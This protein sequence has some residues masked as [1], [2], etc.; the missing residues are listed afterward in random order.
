MKGLFET[1]INVLEEA[2]SNSQITNPIEKKLQVKF[3]YEDESSWRVGEIYVFGKN[4]LGNELLRIYQTEGP[5]QRGNNQWKTFR[6]DKIK[7]LKV[8]KTF[9]FFDKKFD[10]ARDK[11]NP[12]GDKNMNQIYNIVKF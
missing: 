3:K 4:Y 8:L 12:S 1:Y 9:F 10:K 5:S 2:I 6:R 11:F 7:E